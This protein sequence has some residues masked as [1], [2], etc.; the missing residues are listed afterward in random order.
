MRADA[1]SGAGAVR[2]E[3]GAGDRSQ[4]SVSVTVEGRDR[5]H[6]CGVVVYVQM[7][8]HGGY[9]RSASGCAG[10]SRNGQ[11]EWDREAE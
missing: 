6:A 5:V 1:F 7:A 8:G 3:R 2:R 10:G 4:R 9:L 11:R